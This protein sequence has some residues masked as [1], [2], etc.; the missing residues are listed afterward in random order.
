MA[1]MDKDMVGLPNGVEVYEGRKVYRGSA[2]GRLRPDKKTG[3]KK[4]GSGGNSEKD[5]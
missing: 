1:S 2:P 4:A 3:A 5:K